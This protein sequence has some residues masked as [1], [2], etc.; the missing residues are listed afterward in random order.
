MVA[1]E[2]EEGGKGWKELEHQ[3]SLSLPCGAVF[4]KC[5]PKTII[6]NACLVHR[7]QSPVHNLPR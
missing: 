2:P 5:S 1:V 3:A 4:L 7:F 6:Q